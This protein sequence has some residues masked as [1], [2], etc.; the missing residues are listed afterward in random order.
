MSNK[1]KLVVYTALFGDY[2]ELRDPPELFDDCIFVCFTDDAALTSDIWDVRVVDES[3]S[4]DI[5]KNRKYKLLPHRYFKEY[6]MSLYVD[7]NIRIIKNPVSLIDSTLLN[8]DM[9][10]P[11]HFSRDSIYDEAKTLIRSGRVDVLKLYKQTIRYILGGFL[12]QEKMGENNIIF[13]RHNKII[14]F[15]EYWWNEFV[16]G[17]Y[18]DQISLSYLVW[19][20]GIKFKINNRFSSRNGLF[21]TL[22]PHKKNVSSRITAKIFREIFFGIPY[23]ILVLLLKSYIK[24][25]SRNLNEYKRN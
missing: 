21:F 13:R 2:D 25:L 8:Y 22:L 5:L 11:S 6:E 10:I 20:Y 17:V 15:S 12:N 19:K 24:F 3:E 23:V 1:N 7:S 18:R 4:S 16:S 9:V 14:N